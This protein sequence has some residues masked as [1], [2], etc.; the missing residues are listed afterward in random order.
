MI[1]N[2]IILIPFKTSGTPEEVQRR[3]DEFSIQND[4]AQQLM[5]FNEQ[6]EEDG[7]KLIDVGQQNEDLTQQNKNLNQQ[8]EDLTQQREDLTQQREDYNQQRED[9]TQQQ[10]NVA[11]DWPHHDSKFGQERIETDVSD[12][13]AD[14]SIVTI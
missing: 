7:Q 3:L 6:F 9:F 1:L 4:D 14:V 12:E 5:G 10:V 8:H 13:K 2:K 11:N